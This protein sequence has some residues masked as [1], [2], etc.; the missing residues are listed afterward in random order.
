[1]PDGELNGTDRRR[2]TVMSIVVDATGQPAVDDIDLVG[3]PDL[4]NSK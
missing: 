4:I 1:M 2:M 3:D